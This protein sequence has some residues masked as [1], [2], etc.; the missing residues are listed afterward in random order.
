VKIVSELS[1]L[2][3]LPSG[4]RFFQSMVGAERARRVY[5]ADYVSPV[6]G[7]KILD[8][9]CGPADILEYLPAVNYTGL[10]LSPD[11]IKSAK[12]R[13]GA[14][15]RFCC[16]D[17]GLAAFKG[18]HGTFDTVLAVGVLH[19]LDDG[20]TAKLFMMAR[21]A[22]RPGGCLVTYDGCYVPDQSR[23]ARWLLDK[24]RGEYVRAP[25]EYLRLASAYFSKVVP[26]VRHD[27]LRIPYTH[28]I[29]RCSK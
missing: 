16:G 29:M 3:S 13:F 22:L 12:D 7:I 15:G 19:H 2:L 17:V 8:I 14:K 27:L 21:N 18:E 6:P 28:L 4:Y 10:D 1:R 20:E 25:E 26:S 24:D 11:Y 23:I 5:L 9:G